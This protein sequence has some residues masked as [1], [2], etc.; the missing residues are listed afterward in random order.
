MVPRDDYTQYARG[1]RKKTEKQALELLEK[2]NSD[3]PGIMELELEDFYKRGI[4]VTKR[5]GEFGAKKKYALVNGKGKLKIRGFE[6]VRRDW[7]RLA[8]K[9][10][11]Q[12]LRMVLET[13]DEKKALE[14]AKE[15][16]KKL[17]Q[18]KIPRDEIIIKTQL[19]KSLSEYKSISP[20]VIAARKMEERK[21]PIS[22]GNLVTYYIAETPEDSKAKLVR[23]KVKLPDEEGEYNIEYYLEHQIIPAVENIFQVFGVELKEIVNQRKKNQG[24]LSKWI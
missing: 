6:T 23:E 15:T 13:G 24:K 4:W 7:C 22:E 10:Q 17:K 21:I 8:R 9:M 18:R 1:L 3:L 5:T 20:H 12:V 11:D 14:Y 19:K 16:I 2:L